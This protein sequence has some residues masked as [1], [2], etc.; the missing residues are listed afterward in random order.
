LKAGNTGDDTV[1]GTLKVGHRPDAEDVYPV[2]SV[3]NT[4]ISPYVVI[5]TNGQIRIWDVTNSQ[6]LGLGG[7]TFLA[8]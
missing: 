4:K 8:P 2:V 1:I 7:I 5:A 6:L 3:G